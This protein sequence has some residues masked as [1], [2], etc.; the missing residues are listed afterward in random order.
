MSDFCHQLNAMYFW[1]FVYLILHFVA[2]FSMHCICV[3]IHLRLPF[4]NL[5]S[6]YMLLKRLQCVNYLDC[7]ALYNFFQKNNLSFEQ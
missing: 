5:Q 3:L 1:G 2:T 7:C 6:Q 4:M